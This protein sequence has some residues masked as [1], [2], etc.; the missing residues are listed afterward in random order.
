MAARAP[1]RRIPARQT[2]PQMETL[3]I[4]ALGGTCELF[5]V[6]PAEPLEATAAWIHRL[7]DRLTRFE[8]HSELSRFNARAGEWVDVSPELE[9]LLRASVTAF[10]E[11]DGL[12]NIAVLPALLAAGYDRTFDLIGKEAKRRHRRERSRVYADKTLVSLHEHPKDLEDLRVR[13]SND[14]GPDAPPQDEGTAVPPLT[15]VLKVVPGGARLEPGTAVDL[16]GIAKGWIADRA[17]ERLGDNALV[18]CAGDLYAR[19]GGTEG[20]GW[21][22]GFGDRTV[23]LQDMGA[24]TSGTTKRRWGDGLHHLIDPRTGRPSASDLTEVSILADTALDAEVLA[25]T[26]LLLGSAAAPAYLGTR[27]KGWV[28]S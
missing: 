14:E 11:S 21:P 22:V 4:E 7:H 10:E 20:D 16:G 15:D 25:K 5:A 23:L 17:A 3:V 24:A 19:G 2:R 1:A 9:A 27:S 8:P 13:R 12:V 6:D 26:V 18:S 28:L